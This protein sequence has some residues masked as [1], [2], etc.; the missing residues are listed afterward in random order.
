MCRFAVYTILIFLASCQAEK[1]EQ[2]ETPEQVQV[3]EEKSIESPVQLQNDAA[4]DPAPQAGP[5]TAPQ[6]PLNLAI[7]AD[8]AEQSFPD[9]A[10][11]NKP[12]FP[13]MFRPAKQ[14]KTQLSGELYLDEEAPHDIGAVKG[15]QITIK[16]QID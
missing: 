7:P 16:T 5:S 13:D 14:K 12:V 4:I 6:M 9:E 11:T 8:L 15:A 10:G 2:V 1:P 3:T